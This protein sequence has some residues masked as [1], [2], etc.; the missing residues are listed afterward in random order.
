MSFDLFFYKR[1]NAVISKEDISKY[2]AVNLSIPDDHNTN[3][4]WYENTETDVY[5][6]FEYEKP[7]PGEEDDG[8]FEEFEKTN[9]LFNIN[10]LRP[11]FFGKEAF[12]IVSKLL[13]DLDLFVFNPQFGAE[14]DYPHQPSADSLYKC[15]SDFNLLTSKDHFDQDTCYYPLDLTNQSWRYNFNRKSLQQQLGEAYFVPRIFYFKTKEHGNAITVATWTEHIPNVMP[16]ADYYVIY[17]KTRRL[18]RSITE[19]GFISYST[20]LKTFGSYFDNY[21][22]EG[23][24]IIHPSKASLVGKIFNSI[25]FEHSFED[26]AERM[27]IAN[28]YNN[29]PGL[30]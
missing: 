15:W 1:K 3:R 29:K 13:K 22:F 14:V 10:Y 5:F 2:L 25:K 8:D 17:K 23:C 12:P 21:E 27:D 20:L 11:D 4:W 24:K 30:D 16:P 9:F 18:F 28:L 6:C 7:T 26:F 19:R